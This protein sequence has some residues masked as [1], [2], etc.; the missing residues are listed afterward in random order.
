MSRP[1]IAIPEPSA[2]DSQYSHKSWPRYAAAVESA[3]AEPVH[4][5]LTASPEEVARA[6]ASC[7]A[8]LLPGDDADITP[9]KYGQPR[10]GSSPPDLPREAAD[11]LLLQDAFNLRKP[12]L[13]ICYGFQSMNVW[14]NGSL[15]QDLPSER[16]STVAHNRINGPLPPPHPITIV[17]DSRLRDLAGTAQVS[18]NSNHHQAVDRLGD[19]LRV[20]ATC[21]ADGVV[22]AAERPGPA[23]VLGVQWH[24]ERDFQEN[25]FSRQIFQA[26]VQ[27]ARMWRPAPNRVS[28]S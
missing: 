9:S 14:L 20:S 3:G 15:I 18:V 12:I 7:Q 23:F 22:E 13:G 1:R 10:K 24:P 11:E 5:S 27:A 25:A 26:L 28:G 6:L 19:G 4:I 2:L 21:T 16:P 17:Q 8:I